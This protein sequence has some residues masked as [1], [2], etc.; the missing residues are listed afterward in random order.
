MQSSDILQIYKINFTKNRELGIRSSVGVCS[1]KMQRLDQETAD[2]IAAKT[3]REALI[4]SP[5]LSRQ[6]VLE[7]IETLFTEGQ[8]DQKVA[9]YVLKNEDRFAIVPPPRW[10]DARWYVEELRPL[11]RSGEKD[12]RAEVV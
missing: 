1:Q 12:D 4:A 2:L 9:G 10:F 5:S 11:V 8:I 3:V 7:T 6:S